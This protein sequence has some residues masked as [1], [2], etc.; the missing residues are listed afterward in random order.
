MTL[1]EKL[2]QAAAGASYDSLPE[3]AR[4]T[5][6]RSIV[7]TI[8]AMAPASNSDP[9]CGRLAARFLSTASEA[10]DCS[11]I[12][13][14]RQASPL[15]AAFLN[16]CFTQTLDYADTIDEVGH[17]PSAQCLPAGFATAQAEGRSG[18]DLLTALA[19]GQDIGT[20]LS[21][22][23]GPSGRQGK[24]YFPP[25]VLGGFSAVSTAGKLLHLDS[26]QFAS[27]FGLA[28]HRSHGLTAPLLDPQSELRALRYGMVAQDGI[29]CATMAL[30]NVQAYRQ[31]IE[32][33]FRHFFNND[34][35]ESVLLADLG[36][37]YM[38][39]DVSIKA[40]PCCRASHGH[41]DALRSLIE[42]EGISPDQIE[43]IVLDAEESAFSSLAHPEAS[44][45]RPPSG[46]QAKSSYYFVTAVAAFKEPTIGD[47]LD[48][49]RADPDILSMSDRVT[50]R[51]GPDCGMI[52]PVTIELR[53]KDGRSF[54]ES[55]TD[56]TGSPRRP[57]SDERLAAKFRDAMGFALPEP[58]PARIDR[59]LDMLLNIERLDTLEE[60]ATLLP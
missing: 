45:R 19:V 12:G 4:W 52:Y 20:R 16:G 50:V 56:V 58:D 7:D 17:H 22:A 1:T 26:D 28:L 47:F 25:T 33:L 6:K 60:V 34:F 57:L 32:E 18:R 35:D 40:W 3:A 8:A 31:G 51:V 49:A 55:C 27:G 54:R 23:R 21:L 5:A 13:T 2:S 24:P 48:E 43:E 37:R 44:K 39:A 59:L 53:L 46:I 14:G 41:V 30:E 11:V 29:M 9:T 15:V 38:G 42:R 10:G 36:Q